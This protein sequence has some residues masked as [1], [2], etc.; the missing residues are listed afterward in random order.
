MAKIDTEKTSSDTNSEKQDQANSSSQQGKRITIKPEQ[1][2]LLVVQQLNHVNA[3][4]DEL[5]IAIKQL[6]DIATQLSSI[7]A[8][9]GKALEQ[10]K[11]K[12]SS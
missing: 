5:N 6:G 2:Q 10:A 12:S 9:Q 7:C 1:L 4:K 8:Q 3:K 11:D